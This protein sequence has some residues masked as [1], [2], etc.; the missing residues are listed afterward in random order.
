MIDKF[1]AAPP[2]G[3]VREPLPL[4]R[5]V[6]LEEG[7]EPAL[8]PVTGAERFARLTDDHYTAELFALGQQ[9]DLAGRFAIQ[10]RLAAQIAMSRLIRPRD[11]A[12]FAESLRLAERLVTG[13]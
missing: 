6:F 1:Y 5:L 12:R 4:A 2:A 8:L 13:S 7:P 9:L 11:T 3:D 10:A